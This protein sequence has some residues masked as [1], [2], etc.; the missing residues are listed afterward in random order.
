MQL[1]I[2]SFIMKNKKYFNHRDVFL[3]SNQNLRGKIYL[4][5]GKYVK[6]VSSN[7]E[8]HGTKPYA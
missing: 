7:P 5:Y 1:A 6:F 2:L 8:I 3:N 4:S